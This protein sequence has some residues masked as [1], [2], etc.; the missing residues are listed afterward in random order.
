MKKSG[1]IAFAIFFFAGLA[2]AQIPGGNLFFGYSYYNT[3]LSS[4]D[5]AN[6]NGW[7][8]SLE[9][10]IIPWVGIVADFDSHYGSQNFPTA[11]PFGSVACTVNASFTERNFLFGPRVSV[12]VAKFR[13]FAEALFGAAHVSANNGIGSDTSFATALGGG[14]DYKIIPLVAWRFQGD[15]IQTR[16][17]G[18]T[19]DNVRLS[20]GIV[21][22]F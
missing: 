15:Y 12:S 3:D 4:I 16:F 5:R 10:K 14:L 6:A 17:F 20:T 1:F 2:N 8:A 21:V 13:P 9:G 7:E 19:Q 18:A 11:C 22:H